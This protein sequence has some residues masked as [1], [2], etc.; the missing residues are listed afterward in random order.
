MIIGYGYNGMNQ[1]PH[2]SF[3]GGWKTPQKYTVIT[4]ACAYRYGK[5]LVEFSTGSLCIVR[6][7]V[8]QR[9]QDFLFLMFHLGVYERFPFVLFVEAVGKTF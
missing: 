6:Q 9:R 4:T 1:L 8:E 3:W 2:Q 5:E 7:D